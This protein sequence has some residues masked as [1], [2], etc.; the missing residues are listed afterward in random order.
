M[1]MDRKK[2]GIFLISV[3]ICCIPLFLTFNRGINYF[4]EGYILEG[5][6]RILGGEVPYRDFH[7][8]YTPGTIYFLALIL[9]IC[10]QYVIV[11]RIAAMSVSILGV[12]FL[13]LLTLKLTKNTL[14][15]FLTMFLYALWGPTHLNFVWPVMMILPFVFLYLFLFLKSRFFL[16]G[17]VMGIV[18][19]CKQNFGAALLVSFICYCI[20]V[21]KNT[22]RQLRGI[23]LGLASVMLFFIAYLCLSHSFFS[24]LAD[25]NTYTIQTIIVRKAFSVPFPTQSV[26]K[27]V[28]YAFPGIISLI[29]G[30]ALAIQKKNR[31]ILFIPLTLLSVYF[32]GIFPTPDWTHL[33]PL[34]SMTGLL[35]A[36]IPRISGER[37]RFLAYF[38]MLF[39][40]SVGIYSA[41]VRNYYRWEAPYTKQINCF[42]SGRM[43][44]LCIDAK[45]YAVITKTEAAIERETNN[46]YIFAFYNDPIYYFLARKKNPTR[47]ID[48]NLSAGEK[49]DNE[50]ISKL[51]TKEVK[52]IITRFPLTDSKSKIISGYIQKNFMPIQSIYEFTVW[53]KTSQYD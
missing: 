34:I 48:F 38:F 18:L 52:T 23:L 15:T 51:R 7:F 41:V 17:L 12:V 25:V 33:T 5:A 26:A 37:Y 47:F 16:A 40:V 44:F 29:I 43:K 22:Y 28:L 8:I 21:R 4:D 24:F 45:N 32:F 2:V 19:L 6:R 14:L 20:L 1:R 50:V 46:P 27:A 11:E 10:G 31:T 35:F 39:M 30:A 36:L 3:L 42:S 9:R 13:G 53:R 49:E